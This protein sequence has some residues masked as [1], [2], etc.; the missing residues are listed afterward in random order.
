MNRARRP[1][2]GMYHFSEMTYEIFINVRI[3]WIFRRICKKFT[4]G[5]RHFYRL[6]C[7]PLGLERLSTSKNFSQHLEFLKIVR[8]RVLRISYKS[9]TS[10]ITFTILQSSFLSTVSSWDFNPRFHAFAHLQ[11]TLLPPWCPICH[12]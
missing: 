12:Q 2:R 1:Q 11:I 6:I 9:L 10:F 8:C 5:F 7:M 3:L 4:K